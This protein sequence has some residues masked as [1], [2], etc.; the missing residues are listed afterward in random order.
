M[1]WNV[2]NRMWYNGNFDPLFWRSLYYL[3]NIV[4]VMLQKNRVLMRKSSYFW[5]PKMRKC[6]IYCYRHSPGLQVEDV[7]SRIEIWGHN[8]ILN[9]ERSTFCGGCPFHICTDILLRYYIDGATFGIFGIYYW[10]TCIKCLR[11]WTEKMDS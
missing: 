4:T 7:Q 8:S 5:P 11:N 9:S 3:Y 1:S 6:S 2:L 10:Y